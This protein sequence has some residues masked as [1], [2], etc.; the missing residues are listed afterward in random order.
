M[1]RSRVRI[2]CARV[3][4]NQ[5]T[6]N[7]NTFFVVPKQHLPGNATMPTPRSDQ[8]LQNP[9][10]FTCQVVT[11]FQKNQGLLLSG[12]LGVLRPPFVSAVSAH[13]TD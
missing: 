12:A 4:L 7:E 11:A 1:L 13:R 8:V 2:R 5:I 3:Q 9:W 10:R 6:L